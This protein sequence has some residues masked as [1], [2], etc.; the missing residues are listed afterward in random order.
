MKV[1]RGWLRRA[2]GRTDAMV[3]QV[4]PVPGDRTIPAST[5]VVVVGGGIIGV[6]VALELAE[7][8]VAVVLL[9][10]GHIACEQSSRNWGWCRQARRDP[11]ELELIRESLALWRG[12]N[13]RVQADTGFRTTGLLY[14][15]HDDGTASRYQD[16]A[17][18]A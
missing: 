3:P 13:A 4:V 12:S 17:R 6:S 1:P 2:V 11:R 9:E 15:A 14:A 18:R 8:G 5:E 7:R 10:K 16:W